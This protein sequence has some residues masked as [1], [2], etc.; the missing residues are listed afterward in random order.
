M[1]THEPNV[2]YYTPKPDLQVSENFYK[3]SIQGLWY[4][5][6]AKHSD[7]RGFFS[8]IVKLPELEQIIGQPFNIQQIN[9]ARSVENVVR[10]MHAEGWNKLVTVVS[11]LVFSAVA[12]VRPQSATY[13]QVEYFKL[14]YDYEQAFGNGL[15]I[16]QGLA[17]SVVVLQGPVSYLYFV[18]K[19]YAE[20]NAGDDQAISV[21]DPDLNITWP[22]NKNEM[23]LSERDRNALK[24]REVK[25]K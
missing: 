20:R 10:G 21:F 9:H 22:I 16:S 2:Q 3:T 14:G 23:K 5:Q 15:F 13:K 12:D 25:T 18:D 19:L 24:L 11:G 7:E 8:E 6:A 4:F 17:N 1:A